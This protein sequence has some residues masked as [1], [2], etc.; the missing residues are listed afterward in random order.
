MDY[1]RR[2]LD[3]ADRAVGRTSPN[4]AVGAVVVKDGMIVGEGF[5]QPAGSA[6]AEVMAL[7]AAGDR[8]R[9]A[10]LFVTLEPCDHYGRTPPCS[11]AVIDAGIRRVYVSVLDPNPLV[12]GKGVARLESAG[13]SVVVGDH[14]AEAGALNRAFFHYIQTGRPHVTAKWA[15]SLDGK[16]ATRT[17]DSRWVT[18]SRRGDSFIASAMPPTRLLPGLAR[19]WPMI[20]GSPCV[21]RPNTT[22]AFLGPS[23]P[24]GRSSIVKLGYRSSRPSCAKTAIGAR[25]SSPPTP[26]PQIGSLV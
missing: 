17:G 13:I 10:E 24:G 26:L 6:H 4:P 2:A 25:S 12:H 5:T 8:A 19:C 18:G 22:I 16:I 23:R 14:A 9:G 21:S 20:L 1:L 7:A 11:L 3:L 15:M